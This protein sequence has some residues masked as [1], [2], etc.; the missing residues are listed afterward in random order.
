MLTLNL[1]LDAP[2][3]LTEHRLGL[4][5]EQA[6]REAYNASKMFFENELKGKDTNPV[7]YAWV[8]FLN[9][10]GKRITAQTEVGQMLQKVG[11]HHN[12]QNHFGI[13]RPGKFNCQNMHALLA[14]AEVF[15]NLF[16]EQGFS[17]IACYG[18]NY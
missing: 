7:G 17:A 1:S 18:N 5:K 2:D 4:L 15:A 16:N 13:W 12:D 9:Y 10:K 11:I 3:T 6:D 14:G 8:E